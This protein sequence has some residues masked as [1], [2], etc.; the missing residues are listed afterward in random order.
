MSV[1][2]PRA[3]A[4]VLGDID[5]VRPL[6]RAGVPCA[7]Y[8]MSTNVA[9]RSRYVRARLPFVDHWGEQEAMTDLLL[10]FAS[11][12]PVP[13]VLFPQTDGDLLALSRH[14]ERLDGP[15]RLLLADRD[16]VSTLLDKA[17][18][19]TFAQ[20][21]DLPV[22]RAVHVR[23]DRPPSAIDLHF[24]LVVKPLTRH[25]ERWAP[26]AARAKALR[27]EDGE[28]LDAILR[29]VRSR[30]VDVLVQ[31]A[32]PGPESAIESFHAYVDAHGELVAGFTGRKIRTFPTRYG[33]STALEVTDTADV[34]A[35]GAGILERIA[36]RG[37]VK[38][39]F[40]RGPEGTLHL[41]EINPRATLWHNMGA[42]A[43]VNLA[44]LA[45]ADLAGEPRP[46][47]HPVRAG[48]R[49]CQPTE[50]LRAARAEGISTAR[51]LRFLAS[52][53]TRS[54]LAWD[55]PWPFLGGTVLPA[56][57]RRVLGR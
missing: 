50:D 36:L 28:R 34:R 1:R 52:C 5:L 47:V 53:E 23:H 32:V 16:L 19:S 14:R 18:F 54:A 29:D 41:L 15:F 26:V 57:R 35:V 55:D 45:Y 46:T 25:P 56:I 21:A 17:A 13:P 27:V 39:D 48:V 22:P 9:Q 2:V 44:A 31:E 4:V 8:A 49:W 42:I 51:W 11:R 12:Q 33:H 43:G 3:L 20:Q 7:L 40:K 38:L 37:L 24:P 10:A 30:E 6:A